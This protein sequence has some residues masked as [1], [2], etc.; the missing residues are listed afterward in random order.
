MLSDELY[1]ATNDA[2]NKVF[3]DMRSHGQKKDQSP[4]ELL[5]S[6]LSACGAVDIVGILKKRK[7]TILNFSIEA[8]GTRQHELP[9][10]FTNI[11]CHYTAVSPDLTEE[12]FQKAAALALE[13][14]CSVA[15][16]LKAEITFSVQVIRPN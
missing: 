8:E 7:K 11:H 6:S 16:S 15:T 13:K 14:Y 2:G 9:R 3:I 10:Y 12:E 4:V 1:E 5:L